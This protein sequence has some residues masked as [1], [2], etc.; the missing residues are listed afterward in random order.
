MHVCGH[1]LATSYVNGGVL[2]T[3]R[4]DDGGGLESLLDTWEEKI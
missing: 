1:T 3:K 4:A 2:P